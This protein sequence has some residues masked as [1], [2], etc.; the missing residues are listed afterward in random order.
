MNRDT[1]SLL[2]VFVPAILF[3]GSIV[4]VSYIFQGGGCR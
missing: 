1:E 3:V 4:A 2:W